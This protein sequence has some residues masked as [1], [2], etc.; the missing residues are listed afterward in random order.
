MINSIHHFEILTQKSRKL[1]NYFINSLN[2][3]LIASKQTQNQTQFVVQSNNS[4]FIITSLNNSNQNKSQ[5]SLFLET[6]DHLDLQL[7]KKI[8]S[9]NDTVFNVAIQVK[10]INQILR[11]CSKNSVRIIKTEEKIEDGLNGFI[12]HA[13]IDSC[14]DGVVHTLIE[15]SSYKGKFLPQFIDNPQIDQRMFNYAPTHF[16]HLTYATYKNNSNEIIDW[17][18]AIFNMKKFNINHNE[19][20]DFIVRTGNSGMKLKAIN[21]WFC[22]ETG[23]VF[24]DSN[25]KNLDFK[26]VIAEPLDNNAGLLRVNP[27]E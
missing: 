12:H 20:E 19:N 6:L 15:K 7:H 13:I 16:D 10:D 9:K 25:D 14:I 17:Y 18:R 27:I 4:N 5:N 8:T 11:N 1:L 21:Y 2:F 24:E 3:K 26:F 22:A 23:L